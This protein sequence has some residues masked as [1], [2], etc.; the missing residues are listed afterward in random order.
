MVPHGVRWLV[1]RSVPPAIR[2]LYAEARRRAR[3]R[4]AGVSFDVSCG[5]DGWPVYAEIEQVVRRGQLFE[6]KLA[7]LRLGTAGIDR[8]LI[9]PGS[10]WSFWR[11]VG[12]P[13][14]GRGYR[15]SRTLVEG[16]LVPEVGGGLCQ[17]SSMLYHLA[18]V[19]GLEIVE[20]HPHS[21][22]IYREED[23]YAPLG[24]DATV[25][26][27]FKDLR[28]RN[29]GAFPV[30]ITCFVDG[31]RLVGRLHGDTADAFA[32]E[33]SFE[34]EALAPGRVRVTTTVDGE[35][36]DVTEYVQKPGLRTE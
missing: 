13:S 31:D 22:D 21:V 32:R 14:S 23:R 1:R 28:F 27:G 15:E 8:S 6:N 34:R 16:R 19:G 4:V 9:A 36:C 35:R 10:Y 17:L 26:W 7:N 30:A 33:V 24:A 20:R 25:V 3:D 11:R 18:L 2:R 12:A 5:G 29:P